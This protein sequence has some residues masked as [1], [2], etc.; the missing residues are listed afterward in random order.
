[1][2][3][4]DELQKI[5]IEGFISFPVWRGFQN[6]AG[7]YASKVVGE[8]V[9]CSYSYG[10]GGDSIIDFEGPEM[11]H[12]NAFD[13]LIENQEEIKEV[14][15]NALLEEYPDIQS[16]Y[17]YEGE[18]KEK[19][20]PDVTDVEEFKKLIGVKRLHFMHVEKDNYAYVG[21]EFGCEWD[22]EH[23]LGIMM[24]KNRVIKVGGADSAFMNWIAESDLDD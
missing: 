23:G 16:L 9:E 17:G 1:M 14:L 24:H 22:D 15:L 10:I 5:E 19:W 11:Y 13:Y 7:F 2:I 4:N 8:D 12:Q 20:S 21:F 18:D 3:K 6:R